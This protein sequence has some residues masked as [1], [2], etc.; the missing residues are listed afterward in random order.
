V[1]LA[2]DWDIPVVGFIARIVP[3][4]G[5]HYAIRLIADTMRTLKGCPI[6]LL[7]IGDYWKD[8]P[9]LNYTKSDYVEY[10]K[11]LI[12]SC[13]L[14]DHVTWLPG[15]LDDTALSICYGA[16]DIVL[17][18]TVSIDENY[19]YVPLEAMNAGLP[20]IATAYGGIK[21]TI[22]PGRTGFLMSTWSTST[23]IRFDYESGKNTL[24]HLLTNAELGK[25]IGIAGQTAVK[26]KYSFAVCAKGLCDIINSADQRQI[27]FSFS[28]N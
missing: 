5:L 1:I 26:Q 11:K 17:H 27:L 4:K 19:G 23:G 22:D 8:Y 10:C 9:V 12:L 13:G 14:Q 2:I 28:D 24:H 21:D 15:N 20:V 6:H 7:V 16:M 3:Q 18:P 25:R